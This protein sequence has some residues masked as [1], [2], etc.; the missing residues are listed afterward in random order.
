MHSVLKASSGKIR[1]AACRELFEK[2]TPVVPVSICGTR[3][4]LRDG[5]WF[6]RR[7]IITVTIGKPIAPEGKGWTAAI[8]LRNAAREEIS[9]RCGEPDLAPG[10][11][12]EQAEV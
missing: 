8:R 10:M 9:R 3:S 2:G 6:P 4:I 12:E 1:R 11:T 7:G 5:H